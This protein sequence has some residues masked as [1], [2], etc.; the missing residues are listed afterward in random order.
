MFVDKSLRENEFRQQLTTIAQGCVI[1]ERNAQTIA[2][3]SNA[4]TSSYEDD[5]QCKSDVYYYIYRH[6]AAEK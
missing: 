3:V 5:G 2:S 4:V 6:N 1:I